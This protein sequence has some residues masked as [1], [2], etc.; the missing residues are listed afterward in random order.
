MQKIDVRITKGEVKSFMVTLKDG[1]P[2][3]GATVALYTEQGKEITTFSISTETWQDVRFDLPISMIPPIKD[4]ADKLEDIV[5]S[6]CNKQMK[7]I[8]AP[9]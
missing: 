7:I 3:V 4:L 2:T 9:K 5:I 1:L 8:E 6:Q